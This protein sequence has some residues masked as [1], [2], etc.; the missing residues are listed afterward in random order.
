MRLK[1]CLASVVA[2]AVAVVVTIPAGAQDAALTANSYGAPFVPG[3][4]LCTT[5]PISTDVAASILATPTPLRE[6]PLTDNGIV[7]LPGGTVAD[8]ATTS[9]IL[10]TLTQIWA[11]NNAQNS[12]ALLTLF[13]TEGL[14]ETLGVS[15][16]SSWNLE[17]IR[18]AVAAGL[19]PEEPRPAEEYASIDA[20]VSILA[21]PDGAFGVLVLNTDP[22]VAEGD[23]V[24]DYFA[25]TSADGATFLISSVILDP[26]DLTPGYG[27][28]K[29]E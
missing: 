20:V 22:N 18:A 6:L 28:E 2:A 16:G 8:D 21:Q 13:S 15:D 12:A 26:F 25:F 23:Q 5:A 11:C 4:E 29:G 3:A 1:R 9:G 19:T 24:L 10:T 14:Q 27:F 7:A 17:Q